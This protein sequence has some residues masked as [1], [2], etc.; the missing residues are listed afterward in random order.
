MQEVTIDLDRPRKVAFTLYT[1]ILFQRA[2]GK[3]YGSYD[4][5]DAE[6]TA[7]LIWSCV[8]TGEPDP[9]LTVDA[10]AQL[11]D[12]TRLNEISEAIGSL[13]SDDPL[14]VTGEPGPSD[15]STSD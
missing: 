13:V 14:A 15:D 8:Q 10:L 5:S 1:Q 3:P 11:L 6:D 2:R 9:D 12:L 7:A 4:P